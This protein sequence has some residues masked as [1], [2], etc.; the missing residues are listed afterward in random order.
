MKK[1]EK[2]IPRGLKEWAVQEGLPAFSADKLVHIG[3]FFLLVLC[4]L[5]KQLLLVILIIT[6]ILLAI[7][8]VNPA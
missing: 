5:I 7:F 2:P 4:E 1:K 8:I 6:D 3:T